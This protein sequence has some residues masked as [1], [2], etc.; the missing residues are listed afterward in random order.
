MATLHPF[1][2]PKLTKLVAAFQFRQRVQ[3]SPGAVRYLPTPCPARRSRCSWYA[4]ITQPTSH[5]P[6]STS[7]SR[8]GPG[9]T[10]TSAAPFGSP[11]LTCRVGWCRRISDDRDHS[12]VS[13]R[14]HSRVSERDH[15]RVSERD[16]SRVSERDHSRGSDAGPRLSSMSPPPAPRGWSQTPV[17]A[18]PTTPKVAGLQVGVLPSVSSTCD[19]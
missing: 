8:A 4:W 10:R 15:S 2:G 1:L 9:P 18:A 6:P 17:S 14:D 5:C 13:E 19:I 11:T 16:H 7:C 3:G 12:R